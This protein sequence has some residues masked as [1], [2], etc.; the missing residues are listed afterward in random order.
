VIER[1]VC[2]ETKMIRSEREERL[3][4]L[5]YNGNDPRMI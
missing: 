4:E 5:Y 3:H 2:D 1:R